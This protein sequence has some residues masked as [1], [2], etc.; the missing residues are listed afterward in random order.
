MA[1]PAQIAANRR[2][3][4]LSTG[5]RSEAGKIT[6]SRNSTRTGIYAQSV[7]IDSEDPEQLAALEQD[8][9]DSY[10]PQGPVETALVVE[11]LHSDWLLHRMA[12]VES[13]LWNIATASVRKRDD[14]D[15]SIAVACAYNRI[16]DRLVVIQRRVAALSRAFHRALHDLTRLQSLRAKRPAAEPAQPEP[17]PATEI[18]FVPSTPTTLASP[19]APGPQPPAPNSLRPH[20]TVLNLPSSYSSQI[21]TQGGP[22]H[23]SSSCPSSVVGSAL[24]V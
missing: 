7:L 20:P 2:N 11:I 18:G 13:Q 23:P 1:T 10:D 4:Q 22:V 9:F 14:F 3:S 15:E 16:E 12:S 24:F 19:P 21:A 17:A 8:Y 5:P 6:S